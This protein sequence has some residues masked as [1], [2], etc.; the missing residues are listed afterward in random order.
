[1]EEIF[2]NFKIPIILG[3]ASLLLIGLSIIILLK[4]YQTTKPIEFSSDTGIS[5][6]ATTSAQAGSITIDVEGSVVRPGL[7]KLPVGSRVEEA[8]AAAGGFSAEADTER[9]SQVVNRAAKLVDGGKLYFPKRGSGLNQDQ[10]LI[11]V[12]AQS[13][14]LGMATGGQVSINSASQ[15][16]L[17]AL[18]GIGP[19]TAKKIIDN[20]PYQTLEE[21]VTK[22]VMGQSLFEKL[23]DQLIL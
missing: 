23:K 11:P 2:R 17:E 7:Y 8:I 21:L 20:R 14:T 4:S 5:G 3:A 15:A 6:Q 22:K 13:Q 1:M 19:V 18:P 16:E 10:G 9:I 12:G